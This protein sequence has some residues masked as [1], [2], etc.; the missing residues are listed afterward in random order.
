MF[1]ASFVVLLAAFSVQAHFPFIVPEADGTAAK[2]VFSDTLAPDTNVN[3]DK[4]AGTRFT[5]RDAQGAEAALTAKLGGKK[6]E[7]FLALSLPKGARLV[8][9]V[10]DYGV[11][12]VGDAKPFKLMYYP[13]AVI[14]FTS[15]KDATIGEKSPLEIVPVSVF[16][17]VKFQV[18]ASGKPLP[19]IEVG[20]TPPDGKKKAMKTDKEGLTP[21][22]EGNGRYGATAKWI[23]SKSGDFAGKKYD[24]VRNYATLV[25]DFVK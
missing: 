24:E 19:E 11:L 1:I 3:I 12:Q 6:D 18:L 21:E 14:G 4:I 9:G 16:G 17:K 2:V 10:T 15:S 22:F 20:V 8:Y 5:V 13:K 7:G 25:V 23:E